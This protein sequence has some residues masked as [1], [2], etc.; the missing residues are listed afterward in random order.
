M[1]THTSSSRVVLLTG[2]TGGLGPAVAR[3][4]AA[5]GA[6]LAFTAI[7]REDG[8]RL[9]CFGKHCRRWN[10][11]ERIGVEEVVRFAEEALAHAAARR[12]G[13]GSDLEEETG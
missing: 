9:L 6:Q 4:F 11:M 3:A 2:A 8:D 7:S 1:A 12:K 5:E 10:C 13:Q